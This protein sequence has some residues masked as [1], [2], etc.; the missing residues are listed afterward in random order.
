V[1]WICVFCS[2]HS[3]FRSKPVNVVSV[4]ESLYSNLKSASFKDQLIMEQLNHS[5]NFVLYV[6]ACKIFRKRVLGISAGRFGYSDA[7]VPRPEVCATAGA[8]G[9]V[10]CFIFST[11]YTTTTSRVELGG[12]GDNGTDDRLNGRC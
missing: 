2:N 4:L 8:D 9:I 6:L 5:I 1:L 12:R 10:S 7:G 3:S 11:G